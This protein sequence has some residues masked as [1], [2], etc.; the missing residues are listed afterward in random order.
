[1]FQEIF[2]PINKDLQDIC[3]SLS[4]YQ[5]GRTIDYHGVTFPNLSQAKIALFGIDDSIEVVRPL[6]YEMNQNFKD[7]QIVDL[8][9]IKTP[10]PKVISIVLKELLSKGIIPIIISQN[11][12]NAFELYDAYRIFNRLTNM[13]IVDERIPYTMDKRRKRS[14]FL[15]NILTE[16]HHNLFNLGIIGYQSHYVD[17]RVLTYFDEMFF[18]YLRLGQLRNNLEETEPIIRDAD[19]MCFHL[20]ALKKI[21]VPGCSTASPSG[22]FTEDACQLAYYAGM[23]DKMTSFGVFGFDASTD[24]RHQTAQVVSQMVW[25]FL[26]GYYNRK[27]D[28]PVSMGNFVE[29]I[30]DFKNSNYHITFWKSNR[31]DRWWMEIPKVNSKQKRHRLLP[32]SYQDYLQACRE[33]L[34]ER[35]LTAYK[36]F[37]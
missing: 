23:S 35:L 24:I 29:Y 32:C 18:E 26:Y 9:N 36:R 11:Y 4:R 16:T 12:Q 33:E 22:I 3:R 25:Y 30:V 21:E 6:L 14:F 1:M 10:T 5:I 8:G 34:P 28:Y 17:K 37:G 7:L 13:V 19:L 15:N 2:E 20:A 27:Q 31:S